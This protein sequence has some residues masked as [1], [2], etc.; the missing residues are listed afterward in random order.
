MP[1]GPQQDAVRVAERH[2]VARVL[3]RVADEVTHDGDHG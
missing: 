3:R 1:V 2:E